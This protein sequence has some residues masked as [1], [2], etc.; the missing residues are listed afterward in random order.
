MKEKRIGVRR[1]DKNEWERRAPLTPDQVREL[2]EKYGIETSIQPSEIRVFLDRQYTQAGA[3]VEESLSACPFVF[4]IKEIPAEFFEPQKV[5]AFFSHTIKGQNHNMPMLKKMLELKCTLIDYEKIVDE[6]GIRLVFFGNF[7]GFAGMIDTLWALGRRTHRE[8]FSTPFSAVRRVIDYSGLEDAKEKIAEIGRRISSGGL[9]EGLSPMIFG[10]TGYGHVSRGAQEIFD[11]LPH[12]TID[13]ADLAS[14]VE[15]K[16]RHR[17]NVVYK[18]IFKEEHMVEPIDS[19]AKFEIHDYFQHP[20]NYASKF[21]SHVPCLTVLLNC[22]YWDA[23]YPR[24]VTKEYLKQLYQPTGK[25]RLSVIGDLSC[26]VE[27]AIQ[28]TVKTTT[29]GD[30]VFVY[31]PVEQTA[32]MGIEGEGP[33]VLAV[34]NLPC[35]LPRESSKFFGE[36]L[37]KFIPGIMEADFSADFQDLKLGKP[38]KGAVIAHKGK[39]APD[40]R[41][42]EQFLGL[43]P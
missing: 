3:R 36:V 33:V 13:P 11:L 39:L 42:M 43:A 9:P 23:R 18:T 40:Y 22:I 37:M 10:F 29:P 4:A 6:K 34:D 35:E 28:C 30:P 19:G 27:G 1:E 5:Y 12:E 2:K 21:E 16:G 20:Q 25:P 41:Y 31:D 15:E 14:F 8:G 38:L 24:L 7:A 26:D 17:S 32:T